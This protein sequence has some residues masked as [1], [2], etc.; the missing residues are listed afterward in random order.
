MA[1]REIRK[2]SSQEI[3]LEAMISS[4]QPGDKSVN[5]YQA[6]VLLLPEVPEAPVYTNCDLSESRVI[7]GST[8]Y[9]NGTLFHGPLFQTVNKVINLTAEKLTMECQFPG[10]DEKQQG[11]FPLG[12]FNPYGADVLFQAMLIW[13]REFHEAG[14]LPSAAQAVEHYRPIPTGHR[15]YVSLEVKKSTK[16]SMAAHVIA[17]DET[18]RIFTQM[19]GAE[20]TIS[21]NLNALFPKAAE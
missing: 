3:M 17:H 14:S 11:L 7:D 10:I 5:H 15:F 6:Q 21:K 16:T 13:V 19:L 1:I 20:V 9:Q 2:T 18:G 8:L 4:K 12:S